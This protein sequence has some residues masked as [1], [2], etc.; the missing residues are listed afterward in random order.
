MPLSGGGKLSKAG[1]AAGAYFA[2]K[3]ELH[4][5]LRLECCPLYSEGDCSDIKP[6][7]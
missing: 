4:G 7:V 3:V 5:E 6:L 2:T 1:V